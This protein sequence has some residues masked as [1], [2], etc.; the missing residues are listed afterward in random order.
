MADQRPVNDA[1]IPDSEWLY[2]RIFPSADSLQLVEGG[3]HKPSSGSV[4]PRERNEPY[5]VDLGSL[6][7]PDETRNRGTN[8][9]FHVA[10]ISAGAVRAFG[11]RVARDPIADAVA[12]NP[13]HGVIV[14]ARQDAAGNFNGGLTKGDYAR[15]ARA[16]RIVVFAPGTGG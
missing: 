16:A 1:S 12:P 13:A 15:I 3:G 10:R 8:G 2:I 7:T 14:G 11:L 6:C 5:S 9:N 4:R